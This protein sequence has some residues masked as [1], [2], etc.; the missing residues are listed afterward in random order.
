MGKRNCGDGE[1]SLTGMQIRVRRKLK[2]ENAYKYMN[3]MDSS[4]DEDPTLTVVNLTYVLD[5]FMKN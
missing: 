2:Q 5:G 1:P 4:S 3:F